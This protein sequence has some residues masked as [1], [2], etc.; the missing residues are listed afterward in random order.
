MDQKI[1]LIINGL[2]GKN[3][4]LDQL[5][6]FFT[7]YFLYVF[8]VFVGIMFFWK[9]WWPYLFLSI[10]SIIVSRGII[11]EIIKRVVNKPRPYEVLPIHQLVIDTEKGLSFPSGH[12]VVYFAVAFSF[13]GTKWFWPLIILATLGSVARVFVGVHYPSDIAVSI[14][15][16]G[17]SVYLLRLSFLKIDKKLFLS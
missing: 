9:K 4:F 5:G 16:A 13:Y 2:V 7:D 3:Y 6:F 8:I 1:L 17:I 11:T 10:A 14:L 12:T 15:I